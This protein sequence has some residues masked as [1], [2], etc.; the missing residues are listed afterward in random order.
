MLNPRKEG[1]V[2]GTAQTE[3]KPGF[4]P[5]T[6]ELRGKSV[7]KLPSKTTSLFTDLTGI[8]KKNEGPSGL[9]SFCPTANLLRPS[10]FS[11]V[12]VDGATNAGLAPAS[13]PTLNQGPSVMKP[14][15][16]A[17]KDSK[18]SD[19][20]ML[21][22][23]PKETQPLQIKTIASQHSAFQ[24]YSKP[25][26]NAEDASKPLEDQK[27][28]PI[29]IQIQQPPLA[30]RSSE[31]PK[32]SSILSATPSVEHDG[33]KRSLQ[34]LE[35]HDLQ[36]LLR[37]Y[38]SSLGPSHLKPSQSNENKMLG[39]R[40][41]KTERELCILRTELSI[42]VMWTRESI[43]KLRAKYSADFSMNEQQIYKWWWDQTRKKS[44]YGEAVHD[45]D[46]LFSF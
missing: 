22:G 11:R 6:S 28:K 16:I 7:A 46:Q 26:R 37:D 42:N 18:Q 32:E 43:K 41:R 15:Q 12:K 44:K 38:S 23:S 45:D 5:S 19:G 27:F 24:S 34:Q 40:K 35:I 30:D 31:L 20:Q 9:H 1:S 14:P 2:Q 10:R 36:L 25:G 39:K 21:A 33:S 3:A 13:K 17:N 4:R 29:S 8:L